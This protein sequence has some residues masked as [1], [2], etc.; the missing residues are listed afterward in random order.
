M[1]TAANLGIG[2]GYAAFCEGS[3]SNKIRL[4]CPKRWNGDA[5]VKAMAE[6][7]AVEA[8]EKESVQ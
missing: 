5:I 3:G 7:V 6:G 1:L 4:T 8:A 2:I